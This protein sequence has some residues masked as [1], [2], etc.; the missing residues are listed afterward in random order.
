MRP[1]KKADQKNVKLDRG[2]YTIEETRKLIE[3]EY[4]KVMDWKNFKQLTLNELDFMYDSKDALDNYDL[5]IFLNDVKELKVIY[6]KEFGFYQNVVTF[7]NER[8]LAIL[9]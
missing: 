9:L 2:F 7:E 6:N 3:F 4:V 1:L 5:L 8:E